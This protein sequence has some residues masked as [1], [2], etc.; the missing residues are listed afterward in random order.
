MLPVLSYLTFLVHFRQSDIYTALKIRSL[1]KVSTNGTS[2]N[3]ISFCFKSIFLSAFC[4]LTLTFVC[5]ISFYF[6]LKLQILC[7]SAISTP[8][9]IMFFIYSCATTYPSEDLTVTVPF[10]IRTLPNMSTFPLVSFIILIAD[11]V[12]WELI[13]TIGIYIAN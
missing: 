12:V 4:F 11:F 5:D 10:R 8:F 9:I 6:P 13:I 2:L 3:S 7:S 1:I